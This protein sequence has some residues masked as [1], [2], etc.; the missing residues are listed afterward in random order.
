MLGNAP[1]T[2][3][4]YAFWSERMRFSPL[5]STKEYKLVLP[6][7]SFSEPDRIAT[8]QV[9]TNSIEQRAIIYYGG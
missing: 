3:L 9:I 1:K 8:Y 7:S 2:P 4:R 5:F 6:D